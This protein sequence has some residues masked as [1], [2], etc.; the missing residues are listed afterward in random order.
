M[1]VDPAAHLTPVRME[2]GVWRCGMIIGASVLMI[3]HT[4]DKAVR[5]VS[6]SK[7]Q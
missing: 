6:V 5:S 2:P 3:G 1:A 7:T 4:L